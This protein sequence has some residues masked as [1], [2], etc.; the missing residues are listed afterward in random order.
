MVRF[1]VRIKLSGVPRLQGI[2]ALDWCRA[3]GLPDSSDFGPASESMDSATAEAEVDEAFAR[4]WMDSG[5]TFNWWKVNYSHFK[6]GE[7]RLVARGP[8]DHFL[9][10][11]LIT[12]NDLPPERVRELVALAETQYRRE[13][14]FKEVEAKD[15]E[16][17]R[18][19][20]IVERLEARVA[21]L[22]PEAV[23]DDD[24]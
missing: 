3:H 7:L 20:A 6:A 16:I 5:S 12:L 9:A 21:E 24:Q 10:P 2:E 22:E 19:R 8:G 11:E 15:R 23:E 4:Q 14:A 1:K 13:K 17:N 18:L